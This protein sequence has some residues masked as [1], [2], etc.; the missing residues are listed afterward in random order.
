[1]KKESITIY[2]ENK[3][4]VDEVRNKFKQE[5]NSDKYRLNIIISGNDDPVLSLSQFLL[6]KIK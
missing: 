1:M 4:E 2:V 3:E 6:A 5:C